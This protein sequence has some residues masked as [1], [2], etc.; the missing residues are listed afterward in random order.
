MEGR[1]TFGRYCTYVGLGVIGFAILLSFSPLPREPPASP[2]LGVSMPPAVYSPE[3]QAA[4]A[5]V[6]RVFTCAPGQTPQACGRAHAQILAELLMAARACGVAE[7]RLLR[8]AP[9]VLNQVTISSGGGPGAS[10]D[11]ARFIRL[12][13]TDERLVQRALASDVP[14]AGSI[15]AIQ[16]LEIYFGLR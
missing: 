10:A 12:M 4:I 14:C 9:G 1:M 11:A 7:P 6:Q 16:G 8:L 2:G 3:Q 15:E 13:F 5:R